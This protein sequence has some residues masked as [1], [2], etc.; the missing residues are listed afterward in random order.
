MLKRKQV[1]WQVVE[2][3]FLLEKDSPSWSYY[4][5]GRNFDGPKKGEDHNGLPVLKNAHEV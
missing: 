3:L 2:M 5:R 4:F 1:V